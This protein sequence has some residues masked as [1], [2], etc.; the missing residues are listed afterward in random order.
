MTTIII[1]C[2]LAIITV[3]VLHWAKARKEAYEAKVLEAAKKVLG[4]KYD[5]EADEDILKIYRFI[6]EEYLQVQKNTPS[7]LYHRKNI[8]C[9]IMA[10]QEPGVIRR[11][12]LKMLD[13]R[14]LAR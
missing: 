6:G 8:T 13:R 12:L 11:E 7:E 5:S 9:A 1:V 4:D 3:A 14:E 2:T 10:I